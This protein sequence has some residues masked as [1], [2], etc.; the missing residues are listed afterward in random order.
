MRQF[1]SDPPFYSSIKT[2]WL[3]SNCRLQTR[4]KTDC[5]RVQIEFGDALSEK[6]TECEIAAFGTRGKPS[7]VKIVVTQQKY[8]KGLIR[9]KRQS[10]TAVI[11]IV[12]FLVFI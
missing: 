11:N 3:G 2:E 8:Y 1:K 5:L 9:N 6:M 4:T 7:R 12:S 10:E